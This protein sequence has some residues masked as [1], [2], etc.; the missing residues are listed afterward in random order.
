MMV[1]H[2]P[3]INITSALHAERDFKELS[4]AWDWG[5]GRYI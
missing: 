5:E 1:N 3:E 4:E 2:F